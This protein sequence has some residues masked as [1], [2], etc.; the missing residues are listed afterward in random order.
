VDGVSALWRVARTLR[1]PRRRGKPLPAMLF[2]TDPLRTPA[3]EAV[4]E[5]LPAGAA[6]V[7]RTF[8]RADIEARGKAL[9]T[10]A[11]SRGVRFIV[12]ADAGLARRLK[13]DG[14][15]LPQRAAHRSAE[16]R[17]LRARFWVT[18]AAHDLPSARRAAR[19]GADAIVVSPIFPST[20]PSAGRAMG[21]RRLATMIR[22]LGMPV[23]ALGGVNA[24]TA[25][26]LKRT[27]VA[28]FAAIDGFRR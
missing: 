24:A 5:R 22:A 13:A 25:R 14:L 12:G 20:S 3:P 27:G 17:A 21:A 6:V 11:R 7:L 19:A 26:N 8:G 15:H 4:I 16:I 23:Y 1:P 28:G 2:F 9:A 18:A 10:L